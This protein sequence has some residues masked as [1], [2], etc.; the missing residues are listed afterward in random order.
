LH[1][2]AAACIVMSVTTFRPISG[3]QSLPPA[4]GH[5]RR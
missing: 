4:S 1:D 3:T 2:Y 5:V